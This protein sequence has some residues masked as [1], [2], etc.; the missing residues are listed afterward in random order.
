MTEL[1]FESDIEIDPDA[2]DVEMLR[3]ASLFYKYS[4]HEA[5]VKYNLAL[6]QERVKT[7]RSELIKE[8]GLDKT[9]KN[10][11]QT[12]AYYRNDIEYQKAKKEAIEAE[13][14]ANMA[15]AA[16]WA[17]NQRKI[18]LENLV[19]LA[20]MDYF[21]RPSEPRNLQSEVNK[22]KQKEERHNSRMDKASKRIGRRRKT[23]N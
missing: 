10:A 16:V 6:A 8:A 15:G 14:E 13:Y 4:K 17:F 23:K 19:K 12:E 2:L 22:E 18:T 21:A 5:E 3:H 1:N 7:I 9:I 11:Q 20:A